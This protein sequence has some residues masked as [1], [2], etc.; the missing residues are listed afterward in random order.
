MEIISKIKTNYQSLYKNISFVK[1]LLANTISRLGDSIDMVAYGWMVY[2]LTHSELL[3]G[4]IFLI[5]G[6]PGIIL[7]PFM[8]VLVDYFSKKKICIIGDIARGLIV[9]TTATLYLLNV[10]E[11]WQI[12]LLTLLTSS[13]ETIVSPSKSSIFS[14]VINEEDYLK[15]TSISQSIASTIELIGFGIAG[16]IIA[17][18][19]VFGAMIIDGITF[20]ISSLILS[21]L[22]FEEQKNN[23]KLNLNSYFSSLKDGFK[24]I[25]HQKVILIAILLIMATN[26]FTAPVGVL[27]PVYVEKI[28]K[29]TAIGLSML[30]VGL[31]LGTILGGLII[32]FMNK[33]KKSIMI[34]LGCA[35][36]GIF[37]SGLSVPGFINFSIINPLLYASS[38]FFLIGLSIV[39]I[40]TPL[41]T[42]LLKHTPKEMMGRVFALLSMISLSITPVSGA[43]SGS[44]ASFIPLKF[45]YFSMGL[46]IL[47]ISFLPMMNKTFRKE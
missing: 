18:L 47:F 27:M 38:I 4:T 12:L 23:T 3:L 40:T 42:Y 41:R 34:V 16:F 33:K 20:F 46:G 10:L 28:I 1:L 5:N 8:G 32:S 36:T 17:Y 43:L 24:F 44:L 9:S 6:L 7:S 30:S 29:S 26:F 25:I 19:G 45:I 39:F 13:I 15:A 35:F 14:L 31:S 37:I 2:Q 11:V 22:F 21:R